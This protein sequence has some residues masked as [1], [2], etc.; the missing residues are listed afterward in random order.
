MMYLLNTTPMLQHEGQSE[1]KIT[2]K[3]LEKQ[4]SHE[5]QRIK[6]GT[7]E[8]LHIDINIDPT[9]IKQWEQLVLLI[10]NPNDSQNLTTPKPPTT[11]Q[12]EVISV[13]IKGTSNLPKM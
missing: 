4:K 8:L 13:L 10:K 5:R 1:V 11:Q 2:E 3:I 9:L 7:S 6:Q 12:S